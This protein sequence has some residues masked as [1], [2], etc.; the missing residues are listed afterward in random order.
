[1]CT[2]GA[3]FSLLT[4]VCIPDIPFVCVC[5]WD[6]GKELV[7]ERERAGAKSFSNRVCAGIVRVC[8]CFCFLN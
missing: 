3:Y 8:R 4:C 1:M 2:N 7:L 5:V 6:A